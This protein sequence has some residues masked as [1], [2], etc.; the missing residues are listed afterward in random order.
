MNKS[1]LGGSPLNTADI[2]TVERKGVESIISAKDVRS[3]MNGNPLNAPTI[4]A[5]TIVDF[6]KGPLVY[7]TLEQNTTLSFVGELPGVYV[8]YVKQDA[9]GSRTVTW[10]SNIK[11]PDNTAPTLTTTALAWDVVTLLYDG[12]YF[13]GTSTLNF[14]V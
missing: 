12:L 11:W 5:T 10:P 13:S 7:L 14:V 9:T 1:T 6:N 3:F 8:I 4:G 2:F